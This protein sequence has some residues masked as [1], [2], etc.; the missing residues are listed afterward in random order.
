[1]LTW[2]DREPDPWGVYLK[3]P[4]H[5]TLRGNYDAKAGTGGPESL[6]ILKP[7]AIY[8]LL[9][10]PCHAMPGFSEVITP[11]IKVRKFEPETFQEEKVT[12]LERGRSEIWTYDYLFPKICYQ[13]LLL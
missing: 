1:M 13:L 4:A 12:G 11:L 2:K 9:P 6:Q 10:E 5:K 8:V 7:V 3:P